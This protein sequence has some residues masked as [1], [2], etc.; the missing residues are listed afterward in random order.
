M[1]EYINLSILLWLVQTKQSRYCKVIKQCKHSCGNLGN[2][3]Q[4]LK[5]FPNT[6]KNNI[7]KKSHKTQ[8]SE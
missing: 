1:D 7:S 3:E 8:I 2:I 5:Y 4:D 6:N